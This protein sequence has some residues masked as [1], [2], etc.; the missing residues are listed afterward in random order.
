M[1]KITR[2]LM[3]IFGQDAGANQR[4]KIGSLASGTPETTTDLKEMQSNANYLAGWF[5]CVVGNNSPAIEDMNSLCNLTTYQIA[6]LLQQGLAE[7]DIDTTYY[8]GSMVNSNGMVY[9]S[10]VNDNLGEVLTDATKWRPLINYVIELLAS[11]SSPFSLTA[12]MSGAN[13]LVTSDANLQI[14]L[15]APVAGMSFTV[16]DKTGNADV[17]PITINR[18]AAEKIQGLASNYV[19][20]ASFGSWTFVCDGVDW[21]I[22]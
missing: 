6:Y 7:W 2:V 1:A 14:N 10:L 18:N 5:S 22:K 15:P 3:K 16:V 20:N 21:F 11:T 19:C 9:V 13:I 8:Q 17:Y 12:L 4:G